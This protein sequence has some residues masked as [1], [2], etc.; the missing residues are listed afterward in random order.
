MSATSKSHLLP[1]IVALVVVLCGALFYYLQ[2]SYPFL[3]ASFSKRL[4]Q[5]SEA[6]TISPSPTAPQAPTPSIP[7]PSKIPYILPTGKQVY[8]FSHGDQVVGPKIQTLTF[9]PLDAPSGTKQTITL[10]IESASPMTDNSIIISTDNR[11][12]TLKLKL[13]SGDTSTGTYSVSWTVDDTHDKV[14]AVRYILKS[15]TDTYDNTMYLR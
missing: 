3:F 7:T 15:T 6:T 13:T 1:L 12:K 9:D 11:A 14:Y 10:E 8:R 4:T 5:P 2:V